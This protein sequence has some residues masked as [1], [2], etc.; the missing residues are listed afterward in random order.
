M[1]DA[2]VHEFGTQG[3]AQRRWGTLLK[4]QTSALGQQPQIAMPTTYLI[5]YPEHST[6][7]QQNTHF[8][9]VQSGTCSRICYLLKQPSISLKGLNHTK[10]VL[11]PQWGEIRINNRK[12]FVELQICAF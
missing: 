2:Y 10:I 6:Q 12:T 5:M 4:M 8:S 9:E 1:V 3:T 11:Q 7:Q